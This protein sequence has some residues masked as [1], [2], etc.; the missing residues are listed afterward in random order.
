MSTA[1]IVG[2][3]DTV[4]THVHLQDPNQHSGFGYPSSDVVL[5]LSLQA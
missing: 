1:I 5:I 4:R 3:V 2:G